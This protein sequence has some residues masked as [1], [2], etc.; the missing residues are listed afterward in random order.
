MGGSEYLKY[1]S[2]VTYGPRYLTNRDFVD[3]YHAEH[4]SMVHNSGPTCQNVVT[5]KL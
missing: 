3:S 1:C 2:P 4:L 5:K